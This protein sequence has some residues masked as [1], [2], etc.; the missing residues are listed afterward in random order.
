V[1]RSS[2]PGVSHSSKSGR[3]LEILVID[4]NPADI[5][6]A[7]LAFD[8]AGLT[9]RISLR[10]GLADALAHVQRGG[11][12]VD[13]PSPDVIFLDLSLL[14][15]ASDAYSESIETARVHLVT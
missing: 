12:S 7:K 9:K 14:R 15:A 13:A 6:L 2:T 11:K 5:E 8:K 3:H 1:L 10:D 4:R